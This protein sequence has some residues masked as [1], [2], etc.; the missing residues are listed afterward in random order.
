MTENVQISFGQLLALAVGDPMSPEIAKLSDDV[1]ERTGQGAVMRLPV[2]QFAVIGADSIGGSSGTSGVVDSLDWPVERATEVLDLMRTFEVTETRGRLPIGA[3]P[4]VTMQ[5]E[6]VTAGADSDPGISDKSYHCDS[7]VEV[8][9]SYSTQL[10]LMA[11]SI[12]DVGEQMQASHRAAIRQKLL[13]QIVSGDGQGS[14]LSGVASTSGIGAA[15]YAMAD[16][17]KSDKFTT[18]EN[19]VEDADADGS[20]V[21]WLLGSTLSSATRSALLEPGSDRRVNERGR[22]SLS[23]YRA[24][25]S[26]SAI[27]S[28]N[29]LLADWSSIAIVMQQQMVVIVDRISRPGEVRITSRLAVADPIVTRPARVYKLE[30]A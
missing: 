5:A 8:K 29:A 13:E 20:R 10:A 4:S 22:M 1:F 18:A 11:G 25:R 17:G 16:A 9:S 12:F 2:D 24:Y 3:L 23:G 15:T 7:V 6:S 28:T 14:N 26:N 27:A 30:Q 21:A 19:T